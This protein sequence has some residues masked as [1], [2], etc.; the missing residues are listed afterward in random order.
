MSFETSN[1]LYSASFIYSTLIEYKSDHVLNVKF[2]KW[3]RHE[4]VKVMKMNKVLVFRDFVF[5]TYILA[6]RSAM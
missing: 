6:V 2:M 5:R 4:T 1:L 3:I